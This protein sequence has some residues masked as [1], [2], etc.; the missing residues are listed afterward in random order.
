M[1]E[2]GSTQNLSRR[3]WK[4]YPLHEKAIFAV[5]TQ[6]KMMHIMFLVVAR[7]QPASAQGIHMMVEE[8]YDYGTDTL[9]HNRFALTSH[10]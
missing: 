1:K 9:C 2:N 4:L 6:H 3:A 8:S 7:M 5:F 10:I